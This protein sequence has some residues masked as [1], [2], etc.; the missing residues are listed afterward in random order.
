[1][2]GSALPVTAR[3]ECERGPSSCGSAA[4]FDN[5]R[6]NRPDRAVGARVTATLMSHQL[7]MT[8]KKIVL[9]VLVAVL[10]GCAIVPYGPPP[11]VYVHAHGGYYGHPYYRY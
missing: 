5:S 7:E 4:R 9:G 11:P 2:R 3:K 8:M 10:A 1:L 6:N